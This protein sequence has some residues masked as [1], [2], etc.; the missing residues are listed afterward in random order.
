MRSQFSDLRRH[1]T[2]FLNEEHLWPLDAEVLRYEKAGF[3][4]T[5]N[6]NNTNSLSNA[7]SYENKQ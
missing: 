1:D 2:K 4:F 6:S 5:T 3:W 7:L